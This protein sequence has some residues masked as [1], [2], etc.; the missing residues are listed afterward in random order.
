MQYNPHL[1]AENTQK[2][3]KT[4]EH[5]FSLDHNFMRDRCKSTS[6]WKQ[7]VDFFLKEATK[8]LTSFYL[9][10]KDH[11][12]ET[13]N[14]QLESSRLKMALNIKSLREDFF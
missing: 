4:P 1:H 3:M 7:T 5:S 9:V 8:A 13:K 2:P 14:V 6:Y 12:W 10:V 11:I